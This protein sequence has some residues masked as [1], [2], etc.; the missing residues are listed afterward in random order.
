MDIPKVEVELG[1]WRRGIAY[2][3]KP[4]HVMMQRKG[5]NEITKDVRA[6]KIHSGINFTTCQPGLWCSIGEL[7]G[8]GIL[9]PMIG[10][11]GEVERRLYRS[12]EMILD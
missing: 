8:H 6:W 10:N 5:S 12:L 11:D 7:P 4:T 1:G 3:Y 9:T 2:V